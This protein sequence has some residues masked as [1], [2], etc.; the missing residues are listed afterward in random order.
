DSD[1]VALN[2]VRG[3]LSR[4]GVPLAWIARMDADTSPD[5][6]LWAIADAVSCRVPPE[7]DAAAFL[8]LPSIKRTRAEEKA[9]FL[10]AEDVGTLLAVGPEL[11]RAMPGRLIFGLRHDDTSRLLHQIRYLAAQAWLK[12]AGCPIHLYVPHTSDNDH[13]V[14]DSSILAGSL[15]CDGIG[16]SVQFQSGDAGPDSL[17]TAYAVLQCAGARR[18]R[19]EYISCPSCGRTLFDLRATAERIIQQTRHLKNVKI[20]IMGCIVNGPGEM[21]DADFGYVGAGPGKINLYIGKE[22]VEKGIPT[23]DAV[24]HLLSLIKKS[25]K[26]AEPT[27]S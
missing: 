22:C 14:I 20:A 15:L 16:D 9:L 24:E 23:E 26:W 27:P 4:L 7:T 19:T 3:D 12:D 5:D 13:G 6:R 1:I 17:E 21:A 25:G 11:V 2:G 10:D 18:T 8:E